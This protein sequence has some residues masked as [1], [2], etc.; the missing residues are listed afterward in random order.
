MEGP[1]AIETLAGTPTTRPY[2]ATNE[3]RQ[4]T[5]RLEGETF[6]FLDFLSMVGRSST[7]VTLF[8]ARGRALTGSCQLHE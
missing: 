8:V 1:S 6:E 7:T 5:K 4:R 2:G 3:F